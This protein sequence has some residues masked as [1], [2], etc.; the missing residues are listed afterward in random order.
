MRDV[1]MKPVLDKGA[2]AVKN[3]SHVDY[4]RESTET[5]VD[6]SLP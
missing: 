5:P 4:G 3:G 1:K 2:Q 6:G